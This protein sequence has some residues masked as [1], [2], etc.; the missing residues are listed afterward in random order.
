MTRALDNHTAFS[1]WAG[2]GLLEKVN[3]VRSLELRD[4]WQEMREMD[5]MFVGVL[6]I[7]DALLEEGI[8]TPSERIALAGE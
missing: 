6:P 3:P 1:V 8:I 2:I 4:L 7:L 5:D